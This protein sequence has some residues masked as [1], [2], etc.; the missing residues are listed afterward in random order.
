[1][2]KKFVTNLNLL[3]NCINMLETRKNDNY[4]RRTFLA[5]TGSIGIGLALS[6]CSS[7]TVKEETNQNTKSE[8][9]VLEKNDN[10]SA[11]FT[12]LEIIKETTEE[13]K[14]S[15]DEIRKTPEM[16][17]KVQTAVKNF[18]VLY[19]FM[20]GED[21]DKLEDNDKIDMITASM[22]FTEIINTVEPNYKEEIGTKWGE[23]KGKCSDY[24][25]KHNLYDKAVNLGASVYEKATN[26]WDSLKEYA[27]DVKEEAKSR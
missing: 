11:A 15:S 1:M 14:N 23:I 13:L 10:S 9:N 27:K 25:E 7:N 24:I 22:S 26:V 18:D 4:D 20:I 17:E 6:S 16:T 8:K 3:D 2:S 21:F 5:L 12:A 19:K